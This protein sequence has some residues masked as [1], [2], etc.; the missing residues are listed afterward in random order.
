MQVFQKMGGI[1][2]FAGFG[3][4]FF[5]AGLIVAGPWIL[6]DAS[7]PKVMGED[8]V[9]REVKPYTPA[10][11]A[12]RDLYIN[13]VCWHCHS[14]FVRP[15]NDEDKRW[16]PV[17]RAGESAWD[18]PHAFGTRRIGPDLAR[19]GGLR[20]DDWQFAHL[21]DP[22][23]TVSASVMPSFTWL[24]DDNPNADEIHALLRDYDF[25]GDGMLSKFDQLVMP[26][27]D[28]VKTK[29]KSDRLDNSGVLVPKAK[30]SETG[31]DV[32]LRP[33]EAGAYVDE[34]TEV[35]SGD[36]LVTVFDARP[37]PQERTRHLIEFLQRLGTSIGPWRRA[38]AEGTAVPDVRP[39]MVR[40]T[41]T[42]KDAAGVE[43][44][45]SVE[46]GAMPLR[47]REARRYGKAL[48]PSQKAKIDV[49]KDLAVEYEALMKAW[50]RANPAW[51][52][53][54]T[55]GKALFDEHCA[56]CHGP[57]GRGNGPA[58]QHL[59]ITPRDFT[60]AAYRYRSTQVGNKPLDGDL[61]RSIKRGLPGTAMPSWREIP[62]DRIWLLVDYV[63]SF[64]E[65]TGLPDRDAG[66]PFDD[67]SAALSI[68]T[69]PRVP[70]ADL[71]DVLK[72]GRAVYVAMKC[73]NCHGTEGRGDGP[74]WNTTGKDNEGLIRPRD[75]QPRSEGDQPAL[76]FRG[77]A[78]PNDI[79]RTIFTG[80]EGANMPSSFDDF[81]QGLKLADEA[82][83]LEAA[84]ASAEDVEKAK[85][86]MRRKLF[87]NLGD[88]P[89]GRK[90]LAP[91]QPESEPWD[92]PGLVRDKDET[93]KDAE[94]LDQFRKTEGRQVG[95]DWALVFYVMRLARI[96][97]PVVK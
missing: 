51:D 38:L 39:G 78:M 82:K 9:E 91:D 19:E 13:Q 32:R 83:L 16:G 55:T 53:R 85:K 90:L 42:W 96:P 8:G 86:A 67:Q 11:A 26:F 64:L 49:A 50:R 70:E 60:S 10:Q 47:A 28:D 21:F 30:Q 1:S 7:V 79:Y 66:K 33:G 59:N 15:V 57:E 36:G 58:A 41:A 54:L 31:A 12:G 77:G 80:L 71:L 25:D 81:Q 72:R 29:M 44:T 69:M 76:R 4:F 56:S 65:T 35:T 52:Q 5:A 20:I 6:S 97:V 22:R 92:L 95:D 75:F 63:K 88:D 43:R 45:S 94:Y 37:I 89:Y 18:K 23:A 73:S 17:S 61:F 87:T 46:D 34:Y 3:C 40:A 62:D 93:G 48:D 84:K 2:G 74:G 68:P 14:Q 27:P 24:F